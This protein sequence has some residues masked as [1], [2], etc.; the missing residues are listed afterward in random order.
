M[1][2]EIAT[3]SLR[4]GLDLLARWQTYNGI[5]AARTDRA[6]ELADASRDAITAAREFVSEFAEGGERAGET[7]NRSGKCGAEGRSQRSLSSSIAETADL[8]PCQ[9]AP[10][11]PPAAIGVV[12]PGSADPHPARP[13]DHRNGGES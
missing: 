12:A 6:R 5:G 8:V 4:R 3:A 2:M 9:Q 13:G 11:C 7:A 1:S 10:S